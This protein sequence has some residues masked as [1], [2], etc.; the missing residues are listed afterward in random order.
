MEICTRGSVITRMKNDDRIL[1]LKKQIETKKNDLASRK[2]RFVPETNCMLD[3]E[4]HI[5]NL[6]VCTDD[7]L[8]LLMIRL[9]T[10]LMSA[11]DLDIDSPVISGYLISE[12]ISDIKNKLE[13]SDLK[14]EKDEL[15]K[16]EAKL[17]KLLSEDKKTE[18]ELD[19][20]EGLLK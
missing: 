13:I 7:V 6:N 8:L 20:I 11:K 14:R 4:G 10:Y 9:N 15:K 16:M 5:F 19:E 2:M 1:A 18:L 3:L 12:W 17:D